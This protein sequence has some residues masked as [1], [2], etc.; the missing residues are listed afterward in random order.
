MSRSPWT[1]SAKRKKLVKAHNEMD[2]GDAELVK[3]KFDNAS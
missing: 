3:G 1:R 2:E